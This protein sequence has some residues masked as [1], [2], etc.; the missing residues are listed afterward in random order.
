MS[1]LIAVH[2]EGQEG[3]LHIDAMTGQ[4]ATPPADRPDWADGYAVA[5]LAE[6]TGWYEQRLGTQLPDNIRAPELL[7]ADDLGWI[8]VDAEGSEVEIE[9][10]HE[11]RITI[12]ADLINIDRSTDAGTKN[13]QNVLASAEVNHSYS[14]Q[15]TDE[16]TLEEAEGKSFEDTSRKAVNG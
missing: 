12:L 5:L 1:K 6:R 8:G 14:T 15:P 16:A 4:I 3:G 9:A 7:Q 10:D 11:T 13:F 2:K